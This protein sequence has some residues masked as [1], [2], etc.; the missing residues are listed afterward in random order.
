MIQEC[1]ICGIYSEDDICPDCVYR[2]QSGDSSDIRQRVQDH[3][4][5]EY[6]RDDIIKTVCEHFGITLDQ[7]NTCKQIEPFITAKHICIFLDVYKW[8]FKQIQA[9][10]TWG[11]DHST[12]SY[13]C[14]K[15]NG[16]LELKHIRKEYEKIMQL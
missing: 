2:M 11:R 9:S 6:E 1:S 5:S 16:L 15:W 14:K 4:N 12:V 13:I 3:D 10:K 7:I 8:K